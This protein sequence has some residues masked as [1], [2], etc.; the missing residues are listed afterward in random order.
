[1]ILVAVIG[2]AFSANAAVFRSTQSVCK[3]GARITFKSSGSYEFWVNEKLQG[4]GTYS[5]N[6][7]YIFLDGNT[8]IEANHNG[9]TL[10]SVTVIGDFGTKGTFYKCN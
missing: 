2:L 5:I 4:T 3:E 7:Q 9:Q 8:R 1:M 10:R 6:G